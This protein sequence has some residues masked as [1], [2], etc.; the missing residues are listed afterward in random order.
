MYT[1]LIALAL[2]AFSAHAQ[3][4]VVRTQGCLPGYQSLAAES[5]PSNEPFRFTS[6]GNVYSV[7]TEGS[8]GNSTDIRTARFKRALELVEAAYN[9][10]SDSEIKRDLRIV[11]RKLRHAG[12]AEISFDEL[13]TELQ[14][15]NEKRLYC[16]PGKNVFMFRKEIR[17]AV[18]NLLIS[19]AKPADTVAVQ[20]NEE[21]DKDDE[22]AIH[23]SSPA[24]RALIEAE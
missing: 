8:P 7:R 9:P 24:Q 2:T 13:R 5:E 22:L 19:K 10:H 11:N 14:D 16:L 17:A 18:A 23:E 1:S 4:R 12:V 3:D 6:G 21:D 20:I 15:G